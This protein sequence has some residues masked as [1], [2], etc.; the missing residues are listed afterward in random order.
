MSSD[1]AANHPRIFH[2]IAHARAGDKGDISNISLIAHDLDDFPLLL[3]HA[4]AARVEALFKPLGVTRVTRYELPN[5]GTLNFLL[6]GALAGG[7]NRNLRLDRHG[8]SL[9]S[10]LLAMA[11]EDGASGT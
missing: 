1:S 7:V 5:L 10:V 6:E 11:V 4:T 8:K 3:E 2:D 9:S